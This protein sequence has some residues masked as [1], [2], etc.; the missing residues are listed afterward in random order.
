[1]LLVIGRNYNPPKLWL[2]VLFNSSAPS[3]YKAGKLNW[4]A[5]VI[6]FA[7]KFNVIP[8]LAKQSNSDLFFLVPGAP[9]PYFF[10]EREDQIRVDRRMRFVEAEAQPFASQSHHQSKAQMPPKAAKHNRTHPIQKS[11][12]GGHTKRQVSH[13]H[14]IGTTI[15]WSTKYVPKSKCF[16]TRCRHDST[17]VRS[18]CK[19]QDA[20]RVSC[21]LLDLG[22]IRAISVL[23]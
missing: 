22:Q 10:S 20:G 13:G 16:I 23:P 12:N 4:S 19:T 5:Q 15:L 6:L 2:D 9:A 7:L 3:R 1:M 21:K 14:D 11:T 17:P 8:R 18:G